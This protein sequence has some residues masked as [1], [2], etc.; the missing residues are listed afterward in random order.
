VSAPA[1]HRRRAMEGPLSFVPAGQWQRL[2]MQ[3]QKQAE[4]YDRWNFEND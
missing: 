1:R 2:A 4:A 3:A